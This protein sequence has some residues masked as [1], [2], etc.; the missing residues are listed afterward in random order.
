MPQYGVF[1]LAFIIAFSGP[2]FPADS[3]IRQIQIKSSWG[4]L[5]TPQ[6]TEFAVRRDNGEYLLGLRRSTRLPWNR[7]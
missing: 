5:G 3:A 6:N 1:I 4:G 7:C 2:A